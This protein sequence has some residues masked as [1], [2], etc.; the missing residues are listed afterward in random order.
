MIYSNLTRKK[1]KLEYLNLAL[2]VKK[3]DKNTDQHFLHH[4]SSTFM[5]S[6]QVFS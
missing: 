3:K 4:L 5:S 1:L 6:A 2:S